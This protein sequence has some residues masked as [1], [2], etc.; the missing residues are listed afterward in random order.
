MDPLNDYI[1]LTNKGYLHISMIL[2][3]KKCFLNVF[4]KLCVMFLKDLQ[5]I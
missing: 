5:I 4:L 3:C 1:K 2:K